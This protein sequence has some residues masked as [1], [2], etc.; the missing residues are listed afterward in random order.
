MSSE[1][2]HDEIPYW[3]GISPL[4]ASNLEEAKECTDILNRQIENLFQFGN[5]LEEKGIPLTENRVEY[6]EIY[7]LSCLKETLES[8]VS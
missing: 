6:K 2:E 4:Y 5:N 7:D 1:S 3:D 8:S